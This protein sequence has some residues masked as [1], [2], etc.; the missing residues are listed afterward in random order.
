M[1]DTAKQHVLPAE[2]AA[3]QINLSIWSINIGGALEKKV[4]YI[5]GRLD[6]CKPHILALLETHTFFGDAQWLNQAFPGYVV[7][8]TGGNKTEIFKLYRAVKEKKINE[9]SSLT[10]GQKEARVDKINEWN[11]NYKEEVVVLLRKDVAPFFTQV[12]MI[13]F[14][15]GIS[16]KFR[17]T[18]A[19]GVSFVHF[20]YAPAQDKGPF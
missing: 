2:M 5:N 16:F 18:H 13:P 9:D 20:V 19:L 10:Q 8:A 11:V 15:R 1:G 7:F 14:N 6:M 4:P 12:H 17:D 3:K